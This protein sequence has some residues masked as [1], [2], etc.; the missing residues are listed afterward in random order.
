MRL[1]NSENH[2]GQQRFVKINVGGGLEREQP[3]PLEYRRNTSSSTITNSK[4]TPSPHKSSVNPTYYK[5]SNSVGLENMSS[6]PPDALKIEERRR[7]VVVVGDGGI[8]KT[9]LLAHYSTGKF[10]NVSCKRIANMNVLASLIARL[11]ATTFT[12]PT[13]CPASNLI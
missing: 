4:I 7:K 6:N 5:I 9:C 1:E 12:N 3:T 2:G 11:L 13:I 8:G 10:L